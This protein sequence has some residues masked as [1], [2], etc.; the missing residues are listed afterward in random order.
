MPIEDSFQTTNVDDADTDVSMTEI[1]IPDTQNT[2]KTNLMN[3]LRNIAASLEPL[4]KADW[5]KFF[6]ETDQHVA[7]AAR[8]AILLKMSYIRLDKVINAHVPQ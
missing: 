6:T 7:E 2:S 3:V 4:E 1:S 5:N 8:I